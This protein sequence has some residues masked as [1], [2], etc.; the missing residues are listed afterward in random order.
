MQAAV[1]CRNANFP[2][3]QCMAHNKAQA[4]TATESA[5]LGHASALGDTFSGA[6]RLGGPFHDCSTLLCNMQEQEQ[7]DFL[8]FPYSI[9]Y[10]GN[11]I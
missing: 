5:S 8:Y 6:E 7:Q 1:L 11:H 10:I 9:I 2:A 3:L 4:V